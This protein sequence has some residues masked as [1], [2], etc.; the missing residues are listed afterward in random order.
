MLP[1]TLEDCKKGDSE[2]K[3]AWPDN[4]GIGTKISTIHRDDPSNRDPAI[5]RLLRLLNQKKM[6]AL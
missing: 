5:M 4:I 1:I 3:L 6:R 2:L